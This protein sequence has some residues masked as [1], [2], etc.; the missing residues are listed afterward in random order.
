MGTVL[1]Q[2]GDIGVPVHQHLRHLLGAALPGVQAHIRI[3][4]AEAADIRF[5]PRG[6]ARPIIPRHEKLVHPL[7]GHAAALALQRGKL[8]G[9]QV[10]RFREPE[11]LTA[12]PPRFSRGTPISS[13]RFWMFRLTACC[14]LE[15]SLALM[16]K[17]PVRATDRKQEIS[18][19][20][21]RI[22]PPE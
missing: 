7:G 22:I 21:N 17:L 19:S 9:L 1:R 10:R 13:S 3:R 6:A 5:H 8:G 12:A 16:V 14:V 15:S 20:F 11:A 18:I 2:D 4:K